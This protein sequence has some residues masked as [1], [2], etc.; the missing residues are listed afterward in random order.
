MNWQTC[1]E[2][3]PVL[4]GIKASWSE[5]VCCIPQYLGQFDTNYVIFKTVEFQKLFFPNQKYC[6]RE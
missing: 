1:A 6:E 3:A 4:C 5:Q 2:A